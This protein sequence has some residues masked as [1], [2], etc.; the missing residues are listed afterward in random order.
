V[1]DGCFEDRADGPPR[2]LQATALT[3]EHLVRVLAALDRDLAGA[4]DDPPSEPDAGIRACVR[5][6]NG[7]QL[8]LL[9]DT[10]R[11]PKPMTVAGYGMQ[12]HAATTVDGRDSQQ[13]ERL[14]RYLLRPP[15]AQDAIEARPNG[16][17]RIRFKQPTRAGATFTDIS[18]DTFVARLAALVPPPHFNLVRYYGVLANRHKLR[19]LVV[20]N[21]STDQEP[22]QLSLFEQQGGLELP[23]IG[24]PDRRTPAPRRLGWAKLLARVF[25]IDI[26]VCSSC[27]GPMRMLGAITDPDKIAAH[28]HGARAPPRPSPPE[29]LLLV[30]G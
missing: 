27:G 1:T 30:A 2:F 11:T 13:L 4:L 7:C 26:E 19:P 22:R 24:G 12:L 8:R 6:S 5:L 18:R 3:E 14:C 29:Q 17:V 9:A 15:F 21:T 25:T 28:L 16:Q 23:C 20:P 10:A